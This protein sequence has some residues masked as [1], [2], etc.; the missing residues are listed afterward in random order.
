MLLSIVFALHP[1]MSI[2]H[3]LITDHTSNKLLGYISHR[4][5]NVSK[6]YIYPAEAGLN[7][8]IYN[9][10]TI[11]ASAMKN[12]QESQLTKEMKSLGVKKFTK[13]YSDF[14]SLQL[15]KQVAKNSNIVQIT[16]PSLKTSTFKMVFSNKYKHSTAKY[17][18]SKYIKA[19]NDIIHDVKSKH[20]K[21]AIISIPYSF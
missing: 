5:K 17:Y 12:T 19:F 8:T 13:K 14:L 15:L 3:K 11:D 20:V 18:E 10:G 7:V 2:K 21:S 1:P 16:I 4:S 9:I 6:E